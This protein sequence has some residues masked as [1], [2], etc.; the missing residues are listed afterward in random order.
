MIELN[1]HLDGSLSH[2]D[3]LRL[4]K[5]NGIPESD[6]LTSRFSMSQER[7]TIPDFLQYFNAPLRLLE[8]RDSI[9]YATYS[10]FQR[11]HQDGVRYAEVRFAPQQST[12]DGLTQDQAVQA[13]I[14]GM[15]AAKA[16]TG[17][18]GNL[19]LC[20]LRHRKED[21]LNIDTVSTATRFLGKGVCAVDLAGDELNHPNSEFY[22]LI[23]LIKQC[24]LPFTIHAGENRGPES[25]HDA[26][27][28]GA[29]RIPHGIRALEDDIVLNELI[30]KKIPLELSPC[31]EL[32]T[33][34]S[35]SL[36][37]LPLHDL[38]QKGLLFSVGSH[39]MTITNTITSQEYAA[40]K[41]NYGFSEEEI[42]DLILKEIDMAFL[43]EAEKIALKGRIKRDLKTFVRSL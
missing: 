17:I 26:I 3:V 14:D 36:N 15:N 11:L 6:I 28:L 23:A 29:K 38:Y 9:I 4:A 12:D 27:R 43:D 34:N 21:Q 32:V 24:A 30:N 1:V 41:H 35:F 16:E 7:L 22:E 18:Q 33:C 2:D 39:N 42:M 37:V 5:I 25:V 40:L 31:S 19:I 8:N 20:C 13:A 10:L